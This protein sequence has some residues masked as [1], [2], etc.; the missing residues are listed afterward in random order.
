MHHHPEEDHIRQMTTH[1]APSLPLYRRRPPPSRSETLI[2]M[3]LIPILVAMIVAMLLF[4]PL[5][6]VAES[7]I[8]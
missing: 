7:A 4:L 3:L 8:R 2:A 6:A 5:L 1:Q